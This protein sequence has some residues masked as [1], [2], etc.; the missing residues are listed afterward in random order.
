MPRFLAI[1][2]RGLVEPLH[3]ELKSIGIKRPQLRPDCVEFD[4]S[5]SDAYRVHT[6]TRLATRVLLPVSDFV[7]YNEDDLYF[8]VLRKHDF[9]QYIDPNQT[10]RV[11]AH[12]RGHTKLRDQRYVAMK[13]KDALVDQFRKKFDARPNVGDDETADLRVVV[14]IVETKVSLAVDLTGASLSNRGYR[15][16]VGEAPLRESVAAGL[17]AMS[18]WTHGKTLVDPFCGSGTILIEAALMAAGLSPVRKRRGFAFENLKNFK[19]QAWSSA[20]EENERKA[21]PQ[22]P[23]LFGF[24]KDP[25]VLNMARANARMAGVENWISFAQ[26]DVKDLVPP[27]SDVGMIVTNPPYG[28]RL[29]DLPTVKKT[30]DEFSSSMKKNFKGWDAWILSGDKEAITALRLKAKRRIRLWNGPIE[31]RFLHYPLS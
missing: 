31:C 6:L 9:T 24:D 3:E 27:T 18:G 21:A 10:L 8:G 17:L 29:G 5:W 23:F 11:E 12:V 22:K 2:S 14:R 30:M 20:R 26:K 16:Q 28:Q 7:A 4:G 25:H 1:T 15:K 13:V 19:A